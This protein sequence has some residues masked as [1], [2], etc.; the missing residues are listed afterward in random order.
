VA[1]AAAT[2]SPAAAETQPVQ[3]R[4]AFS[5][6]FTP[7]GLSHLSLGDVIDQN[8][9]TECYRAVLRASRASNAAFEARLDIETINGRRIT[10]ASLRGTRLPNG[11]KACVE[12]VAL[13]SR[14]P[15]PV[16]SP[17][18]LSATLTFQAP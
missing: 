7:R 17:L 5:A 11:L 2:S 12:R 9:L 10:Y 14:L 8:G 6:T 13:G 16:A 18:A 15:S 3:A 1:A 4:I